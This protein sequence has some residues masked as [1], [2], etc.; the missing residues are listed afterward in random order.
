MAF[1]IKKRDSYRWTVEHTLEVK[2]G[3]PVNISFD[4]EFRAL[5]KARISE[6]MA[7][8][9]TG[10]MDDSAFIGEVLVGWHDVRSAD[11]E[12]WPFSV[13]A[14]KELCENYPGMEA[15]ISSAW[16]RS[17]TGGAVRKN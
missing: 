10:K 4:A 8:V 12:S 11:G 7:E 3:K 14:V 13:E 6:I 1:I 5:T 2:D 17:V 9:S 16:V 15:S